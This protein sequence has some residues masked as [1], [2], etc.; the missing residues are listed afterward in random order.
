M[1]NYKS[2]KL[3]PGLYFV[4]TPIGTARDITL[5]ALDI[6]ASVDVLA[7]EDTRTLKK[8]LEIHGIQLKNRTLISYH[9]HNGSKIDPRFSITWS[10]VNLLLMHQ[11]PEP[12]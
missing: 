8:L 9:D 3:S 4:S 1:V 5:R 11:K 6:L 2:I 7:A 12:L 10:K